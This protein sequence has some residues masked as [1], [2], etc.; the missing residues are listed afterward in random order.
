MTSSVRPQPSSHNVQLGPC[1]GPTLA[2]G[3]KERAPVQALKSIVVGGDTRLT[4][5]SPESSQKGLAPDLC[6]LEWSG[7]FEPRSVAHSDPNSFL[8]SRRGS[9]SSVHALEGSR[10]GSSSSIQELGPRWWPKAS[11]VL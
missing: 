6:G 9:D 1:S 8:A 2:K 3:D 11:P 7:D 5:S 4:L 10:H